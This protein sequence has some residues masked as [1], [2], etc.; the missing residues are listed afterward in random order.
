M[1]IKSELHEMIKKRGGTPPAY[2]GVA[3]A[4]DVLNELPG[5]SGGG[6]ADFGI[7]TTPTSENIVKATFTVADG[8][9][10]DQN[11]EG[12]VGEDM[13]GKTYI[14]TINGELYHAEV[15]D[16]ESYS[17]QG[18]SGGAVL[19]VLPVGENSI[20]FAYGSCVGA[21]YAPEAVNMA[22]SMEDGTYE[23]TF[24]E[25]TVEVKTIDP[26][27]LPKGE[28]LYQASGETVT[29]D[30]FNALLNSLASAGY[31]KLSVGL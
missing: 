6:G 3:A 29:A 25:G 30:E 19:K 23:I 2:G 24:Q 18:Y 7:V 28:T 5:G 17:G 21:G 14:V 11:W 4:L 10:T 8:Q 13:I 9:I 27:Y 22:N 1:S 20:V 16:G 26:L 31:I 15:V 12:I